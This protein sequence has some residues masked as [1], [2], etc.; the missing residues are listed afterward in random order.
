MA[1]K[2]TAYQKIGDALHINPAAQSK[3]KELFEDGKAAA[4]AIGQA[5]A[6]VGAVMAVA[7]IVGILE[8]KSPTDILYEK[9]QANFKA[10]AAKIDAVSKQIQR[11]TLAELCANIKTVDQE[12]KTWALYVKAHKVDPPA[13][14]IER[15]KMIEASPMSGF[16]SNLIEQPQVWVR[17]FD[18]T[19]LCTQPWGKGRYT[20]PKEESNGFVWEYRH[21]LPLMLL[22]TRSRLAY[23]IATEGPGFADKNRDAFAATIAFMIQVHDRII[24]GFVLTPAPGLKGPDGPLMAFP[25]DAP[26]PGH[27]VPLKPQ[28]FSPSYWDQMK[29]PCGAVDTYAGV[30]AFEVFPM[31]QPIRHTYFERFDEYLSAANLPLSSQPTPQMLEKPQQDFEAQRAVGR[32]VLAKEQAYAARFYAIFLIRARRAWRELYQSLGLDNVVGAADGYAVAVGIPD[33]PH[34]ARHYAGFHSLAAVMQPS[35]RTTAELSSPPAAPLALH[36]FDSVRA[37]ADL[38]GADFA[39]APPIK[40]GPFKIGKNIVSLKRILDGDD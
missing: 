11:Q 29:T 27:Y 13:G 8:D 20:P 37:F 22:I 25:F 28:T 36:R 26:P 30:G 10:I 31:S 18:E 4:D 17:T 34:F 16:T 6:I 24:S 33:R 21:F 3:L 39:H 7:K 15:E 32:A 2:K 5:V 1:N 23:L 9:L 40:I 14:S 19:D 38:L 12:T 35:A